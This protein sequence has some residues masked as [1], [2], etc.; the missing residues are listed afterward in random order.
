MEP[1][2]SVLIPAYNCQ[3]WIADTLRSA[4]N[5]TWHKKEIIVVDDGSTDSTLRIARSFAGEGVQ[6]LSQPNQG[7]AVARNTALTVYQGDYIQWLDADDIL[8]P[9]KIRFQVMALDTCR[10]R[11]TLI[12]GAW[13]SFN[14]RKKNAHFTPSPL[15]ADLT[16]VEWLRRK[17][18]CNVHMQTDNWLVSRELT[19]AAGPWDAKL[20]RDNDG[21]YFCRVILESDGIRF[22]P[23]AKSYYRHAGYS[24]ISYIGASDKKLESY[25]RSMKLHMQY[26]RSLEDSAATRQ[27]CITYIKTNIHQFYP[28]R[29]DLADELRRAAAELEEQIEE[30]RLS[31]KYEWIVRLFGWRAGR[32]AQ[33]TMP[34]LK[35]QMF[36]AWDKAMFGLENRTWTGE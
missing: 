25:C 18:A 9:D 27:A 15:W 2:V 7:A 1:L 14:Y 23:G 31:W 32:Q 13:A 20:F 12:S 21:E 19:E 3:H 6:V 4:L 29:V 10:S 36:I 28:Y 17:L 11:R 5:Q 34:R 8:H 22:I 24:S 16:P 26:L 33:I 30:P 35:A